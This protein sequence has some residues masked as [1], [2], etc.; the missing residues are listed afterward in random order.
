M[1]LNPF[2]I[3]T[4]ILGGIVI[5]YLLKAFT[6]NNVNANK[7]RWDKATWDEFQETMMIGAALVLYAGFELLCFFNSDYAGLQH[8]NVTRTGLLTIITNLFTYKFTKSI[9]RKGSNG[10]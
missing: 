3:P 4:C 1:T 9:P 10:G 6:G 8:T 7:E 2:I 5:G